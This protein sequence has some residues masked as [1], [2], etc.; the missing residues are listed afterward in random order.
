MFRVCTLSV[1]HP[2]L[3][4]TFLY[5]YIDKTMDSIVRIGIVALLLALLLAAAA[6]A[7]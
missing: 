1:P 3:R 5:P 6:Q 7:A 4:I 2:A